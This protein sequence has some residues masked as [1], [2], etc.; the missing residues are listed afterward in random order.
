MD[1][2]L[3]LPWNTPFETPPFHLIKAIHFRPAA[4]EAVKLASEEIKAITDNHEQPTFYNTIVKLERAGEILGRISSILFNL[5]SADTNK[6]IQAVAQEVS[7]LLTRFSNDITLNEILF[8][9]IK[10]VYGSLETTG[11]NTEQKI[12]TERKF[13]SF[14]LGGAGLEE[15]EKTGDC[16][17]GTGCRDFWNYRSGGGCGSGVERSFELPIVLCLHEK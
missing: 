12:L 2:P 8:N 4:E 3:L 5:N 14:M 6:D 9:R 1:N 11:L 15:D 10:I 17:L 16:G 13:R 7:P